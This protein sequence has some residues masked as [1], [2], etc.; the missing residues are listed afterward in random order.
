MTKLKKIRIRGKNGNK[1]FYG[2]NLFIF[3]LRITSVETFLSPLFQD[4][5]NLFV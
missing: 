3:E 4:F 5:L 2:D 1:K